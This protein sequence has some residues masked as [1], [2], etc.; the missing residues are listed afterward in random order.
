[1]ANYVINAQT[2]ATACETKLV[3]DAYIKTRHRG[4]IYR[5]N[6][7]IDSLA[8][9]CNSWLGARSRNIRSNYNP[10]DKLRGS[11]R[12][13]GNVLHIL[14]TLLVMQTRALPTKQQRTY[15]DTDSKLVGIDNRCSACI[16]HDIT[17]FVGTLTESNRTIK[18]FGGI[19]HT[20]QILTGTIKW[21]WCDN[22]GRVHKHTIPN[23]YYV[24]DGGV[25]LLS[26]QHW[27]KS[28]KGKLQRSTGETTNAN[29]CILHWGENKQYS[30]N[31]PLDKH[32][33]VAT[34]E[35][36]PG[37]RSYDVYCQQA[38]LDI[39]HDDLHP[40]VDNSPP[41]ADEE[42]GIHAQVAITH[43]NEWSSTHGAKQTT[44]DLNGPQNLQHTHHHK[45]RNDTMS[46]ATTHHHKSRNDTMSTATRELL[47]LHHRLGH[48]PF[49]KLQEMA[50]QGIIPSKYAKCEIPI[51]LACQY[52]KQTK[53]P[54]R[55]KPMRQYHCTKIIE[56]GEVVSVDQ[57]VSPTAGLIAQM[58]GFITNK[59]YKY[60]T[61]FVDQATKLGY[62]Y[63]QKTA[64]AEETLIGLL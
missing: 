26:P 5:L 1:M 24:P 14:T 39:K 54:W 21:R 20:S 61:V 50:R 44:F 57:L 34:F 19:R 51:C 3:N 52:A 13:K 17:D 47:Q 48:T 30:L 55:N 28:Q 38:Q 4:L 35:L 45:S 62:I 49:S 63:L 10:N 32:S 41:S 29:K 16:S 33:N 46:T 59:R 23:S 58:T 9:R 64:S 43:T 22:Q 18:G 53:R 40:K 42:G 27:A 31:V 6:N 11:L 37:Y 60:A 15:F 36:A 12:I 2:Y 8:D 7:K 25:R 56:P